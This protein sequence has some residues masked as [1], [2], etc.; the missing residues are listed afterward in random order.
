M[1]RIGDESAFMRLCYVLPPAFLVHINT[2]F[3]TVIN[4]GSSFL[5]AN[6]TLHD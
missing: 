4:M 6:R 1:I 2:T 5:A 3:G